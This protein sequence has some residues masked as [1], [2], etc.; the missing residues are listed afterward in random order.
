MQNAKIGTRISLSLVLPIVGLLVFSSFVVIEK[1]GVSVEMESLQVLTAFAPKI[2]AVVHEL[3]K[4]RGMSAVYIGSKGEK[5]AKELPEQKKLTDETKTVMDNDL[6]RIDTKAY[7]EE[8][9]GKIEAA[10]TALSE[11]D[12]KRQGVSGLTLTVPQMAGYYTPTIA[13]LLAIIEVMPTLSNDAQV[14]NDIAAYISFLEGKERAGI[15]RAMGGAGFGAGKF[16]PGV[17]QNFISL[18][19]QQKTYLGFFNIYASQEQRDFY[20]KKVQGEAV[21]EVE[22]MRKI[23]IESIE[24]K[25][26][27]GIEG[28]YWFGTITKKINLL[29]EVEDNIAKHLGGLTEVHGGAAETA[30][31]TAAAAT[32]VLLIVT[33][34]MVVSIVKGITGPIAGITQAMNILAQGDKSIEIKGADRGDE[35]GSM[36]QAVEVFKE[37]MIKADQLAEEQRRDNEIKEK[38]VIAL[39]HLTKEFEKNVTSV[40]GAVAS[41]SDGMKSTAEGMAATAEETSTQATTVAAAAEEASTNVQTVASA[42][43]ELSSSIT[44]IARQVSQSSEIAGKAV[45]DA[46]ETNIKIQGLAEAA[47]KIG[48]VVAMITDIADQTNLLALNATIEAARAGDA[49]KG[50]AVVASEVKNLAN[51]TAKAT[52]EIGSQIGG[53]QTATQEAVG[54]IQGISKTIAEINEIAA[55][56]AS[57]VEEQGAAT[58]EIARNVEQA[59]AGTQDVTSNISGVNQAADDTGKAANSVLEAVGSLTMQSDTLRTQVE[60]FLNGIKAA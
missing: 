1:R 23:A 19:A 18:I 41:A 27:Q 40:L 33:L 50:F 9:V 13:K 39:D 12:A 57:A 5:F 55:T 44:E 46:E 21:D 56:I 10:L 28:P 42:A 4:E 22:R 58:Q 25:D 11:L 31:Y 14:N 52:E 32:A 3:Q 49:G 2:S 16:E 53:I 15:E 60:E 8:F 17:Y 38:R 48:E 24:T 37:N 35:I 36:A 26:I 54:A 7:G 6:K 34:I 47:N 30:F 51:Q 59:S 43:E 20:A 29:K 45:T